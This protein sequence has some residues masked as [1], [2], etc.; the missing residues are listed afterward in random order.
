VRISPGELAPG[1]D[2]RGSLLAY[3]GPMEYD[4]LAAVGFGLE[5]AIYFGGFPFPESWAG[6]YG[7]PTIPMQWIVVPILWLMNSVY[8]FIRNYGIAIIVLTFVTKVLFYPLTLKSMK[9]MKAMQALAPQINALRAK[10]KN[11][12]QRLQRETMELYRQNK[13]NPM[14]GCLPILVQIPIFYALYVALSVSAELQNAPFIRFGVLPE[15]VPWLGGQC[16]WICDLAVYDP[17][18]ILP[19]LMG[20]SMFIQ[21][22]MAPMVGDPRQAKLM[23][24]MPI[25]FTF[26]FLGF[27]SGLVLYWL[28][29]NVLTIAQQ[30][31][32]DRHARLASAAEP[33]AARKAEPK[34]RKA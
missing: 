16:V 26:M 29:N 13:V 17:T 9:S 21:Q 4:R 30:Y 20:A 3:L 5:K 32:V 14:G 24:F 25:L 28:I 19:I 22:K 10:Y 1:G 34:E 11:D 12:N 27:P 33:K 7:A 6:R 15:W 31:L 23:M 8:G 2:W 18:Y